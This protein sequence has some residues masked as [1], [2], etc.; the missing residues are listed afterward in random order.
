M[1]AHLDGAAELAFVVGAV[2]QMLGDHVGFGHLGVAAH[3]LGHVAV[4]AGHALLGVGPLA[5][6]QVRRL[7]P[8]PVGLISL[9]QVPQK[10]AD[11]RNSFST[12]SWWGETSP[13]LGPCF[14]RPGSLIQLKL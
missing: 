4:L 11:L 3:G 7:H 10:S 9:W 13:G 8:H 5:P 12:V 1:H 2:E 14:R 6:F